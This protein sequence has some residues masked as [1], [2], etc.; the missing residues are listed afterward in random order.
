MESCLARLKC[1]EIGQF[2]FEFY[3]CLHG[4]VGPIT[5]ETV[6]KSCQMDGNDGTKTSYIKNVKYLRGSGENEYAQTE[7]CSACFAGEPR[8]WENKTETSTGR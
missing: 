3:C 1:Y 7:N 5:H 8:S 4:S 2:D 6:K